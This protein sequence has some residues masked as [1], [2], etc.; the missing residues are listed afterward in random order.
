VYDSFNPE[1]KGSG[2]LTI[3]VKRNDEGPRFDPGDY[4]AEIL[5][6]TM[7]GTT[8]VTVHAVDD[9]EV[10]CMNISD[11]TSLQTLNVAV[12]CVTINALNVVH[13]LSRMVWLIQL[14]LVVRM[15]PAISSML[16]QIQVMLSYPGH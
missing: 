7:I 3:N 1:V 12:L 5:E 10:S 13:F 6:T 16:F 8:V 4:T 15:R 9:T 11:L 14:A 2:N